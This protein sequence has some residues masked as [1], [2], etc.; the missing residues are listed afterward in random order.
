MAHYAPAFFVLAVIAGAVGFGG[1]ENSAT[2]IAE[3]LFV[4]FVTLF[5]IALITSRSPPV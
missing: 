1:I 5:L 3:I 2:W 4:L